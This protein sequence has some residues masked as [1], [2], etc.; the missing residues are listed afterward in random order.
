MNFVNFT[1]R[2]AVLLVLAVL[3]LVTPA[4]AGDPTGVALA[5]VARP[6]DT[7]SST[8]TGCLAESV[9][10]FAKTGIQV[11]TKDLIKNC[12]ELADREAKRS[13]QVAKEARKSSEEKGG[14]GGYYPSYGYN[15]H[16]IVA[17][18]SRGG[19]SRVITT[20]RRQATSPLYSGEVATYRRN[21]N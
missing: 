13:E 14:Y 9:E 7:N 20:G 18:Y 5:G 4:L 6:V 21:P 2:F 15:T 16:G 12:R 19:G 3:V 8:Y 10:L 17:T 1:T 11:N